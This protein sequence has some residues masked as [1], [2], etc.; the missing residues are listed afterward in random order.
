MIDNC[1]NI[2][3]VMVRLLHGPN[4]GK[5]AAA[6]RSLKKKSNLGTRFRGRAQPG[7]ISFQFQVLFKKCIISKYISFL[8]TQSQLSFD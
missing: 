2:L 4:W 5:S 8:F 3:K 6:S 7:H 1:P